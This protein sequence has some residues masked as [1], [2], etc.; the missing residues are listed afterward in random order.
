MFLLFFDNRD[1]QF[2]DN[3]CVSL[4][5]RKSL[6]SGTYGTT[7]QTSSVGRETMDSVMVKGG[8]Q[9]GKT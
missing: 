6:P 3:H 1:F 4:I 9:S 8:S 2:Y 7:M 5:R